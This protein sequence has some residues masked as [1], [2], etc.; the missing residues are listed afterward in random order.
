MLNQLSDFDGIFHA[1]SDP[2]RRM[3]VERLSRGEASVSE[4]AKPLTMSMP[5]VIQHLGVLEN[6]GLV[7]TRKDGRTRICRLDTQTLGSAEQWIA[8]RRLMM[9]RNLDRLGAYLDATEGRKRDDK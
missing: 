7:T 2:S 5:S 1:L 8:E 3:M 6:C 4:L 9:E